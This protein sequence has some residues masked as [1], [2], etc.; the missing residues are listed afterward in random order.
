MNTGKLWPLFAAIFLVGC[1]GLSG[2]H[3]PHVR[4]AQVQSVA[5]PPIYSGVVEAY[6]EV[7]AGTG[8]N[9]LRLFYPYFS[10]ERDLPIVGAICDF[11][12]AIRKVDGQAG[13]QLVESAELKVIVDFECKPPSAGIK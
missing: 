1:S 9:S 10:G 8:K 6:A 7:R 4:N 5:V 3:S 11:R 13:E 12:Y 2:T